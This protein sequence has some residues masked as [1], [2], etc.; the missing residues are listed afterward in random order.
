MFQ[1]ELGVGGL[2]SGSGV[3][4]FDMYPFWSITRDEEEKEIQE[5]V[6]AWR[7]LRAEWPPT[8]TCT[9]FV[10]YGSGLST[11]PWKRLRERREHEA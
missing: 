6:L 9:Y 5:K 10:L 8:C 4:S 2:T 7:V 3:L 1:L 11:H